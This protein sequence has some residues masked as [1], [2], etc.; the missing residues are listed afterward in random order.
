MRKRLV[1]LLHEHARAQEPIKRDRLLFYYV[2]PG[3]SRSWPYHVGQSDE[4]TLNGGHVLRRVRTEF[5][6]K[7]R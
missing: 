2:G 3:R 6:H 4:K 5:G 1:E 7:E